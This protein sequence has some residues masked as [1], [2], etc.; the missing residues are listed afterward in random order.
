MISNGRWMTKNSQAINGWLMLDKPAGITSAKAVSVVKRTLKPEKIGHGGTLDP[1][2]TGLLPLALGEATKTF[3]YM[4]VTDKSYEFTV[5]WGEERDTDDAEGKVTASSEVRPIR[6]Q[7]E[8][9][10]PDFMGKIQ[11]TPPDYSAIHQNGQR[12]YAMA[13]AGQPVELAAR[14]VEVFDFRILQL[15]LQ[16]G[17]EGSTSFT[18]TCG[19]GTYIRAVA[20]DL[21]RKLGCYGYISALRRTRIGKFSVEHAISLADLEALGHNPAPNGLVLPVE[22]MLDDIPALEVDSSNFAKLRQGQGVSIFA[23]P[24]A[25]TLAMQASDQPVA[26]MH[27][28]KVVAICR[29]ES[30]LLKPVRVFNH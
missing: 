10:M 28:S 6:A 18:L 26:L 25:K 15:P 13:R 16:G 9:F 19:K 30:G 3:N 8:A 24:G 12:A 20:R 14:E 17:A 27:D 22:S 7:I 1:M 21:G 2:A 5:T 29:M 4:V 11:Q 23:I